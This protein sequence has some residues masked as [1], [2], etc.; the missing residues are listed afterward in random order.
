M[1]LAGKACLALMAA[2]ALSCAGAASA[3]C[4]L[5]ETAEFH[6][7]PHSASPVV[8]GE[9]KRDTTHDSSN[10]TD[11]RDMDTIRNTMLPI[12]TPSAWHPSPVP[13]MAN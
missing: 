2:S 13:C 1:K 4:N 8:D 10:V 3:D 7:D 11:R 6:V 12:R 9:I 5:V